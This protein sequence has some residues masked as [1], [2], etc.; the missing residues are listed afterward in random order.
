MNAAV[1]ATVVA[2][3][4]VTIVVDAAIGGFL[5]LMKMILNFCY[6][7]DASILAD[8]SKQCPMTAIYSLR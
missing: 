5:S 8:V 1:V 6:Y 2:A 4:V 7:H 3:M